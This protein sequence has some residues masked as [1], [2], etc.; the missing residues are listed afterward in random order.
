MA[1]YKETR[2][3]GTF[4]NL[5]DTNYCKVKQI[6]IK[7]NQAPSYQY[8]F[9]REEVWV[10]VQGEGELNLNGNKTQVSTGQIIH[11]PVKAKHQI[12]NNTDK[13]LIFIEVQMGEYFG[14]D[15]IVRH[16]DDYNRS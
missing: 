5:L 7:P 10:V 6:I 8:H 15:D 16:S 11:V 1:N 9:K 12:T 14:E 13:D 3:W 2:P 4:E